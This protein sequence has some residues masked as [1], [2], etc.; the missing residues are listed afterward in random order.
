MRVLVGHGEQWHWFICP[1]ASEWHY[2]TTLLGLHGKAPQIQL[3]WMSRPNIELNRMRQAISTKSYSNL[4]IP[5]NK[6][7]KFLAQFF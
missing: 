2:W 7:A 6:E 1:N 5:N 4:Y 3:H